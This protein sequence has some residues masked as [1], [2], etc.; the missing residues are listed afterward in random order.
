MKKNIPKTIVKG[1][2]SIK[3]ITEKCMHSVIKKKMQQIM[4]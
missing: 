4:E 2:Q 1:V 3:I